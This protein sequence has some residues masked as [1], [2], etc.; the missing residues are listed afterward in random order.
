[1]I[2]LFATLWVIAITLTVARYYFKVKKR[3]K[4]HNHEQEK[5]HQIKGKKAEEKGSK[6]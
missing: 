6:N 1:M 4:K 3:L 5:S 2:K